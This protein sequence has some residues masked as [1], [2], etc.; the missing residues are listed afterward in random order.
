[1]KKSLIGT[2]IFLGT[3]ITC[4]TIFA[5]MSAEVSLSASKQTV[6]PGEEVIV[7]LSVKDIQD[8]S[9]GINAIEGVLE[10]DSSVFSAVEQNDSSTDF[11]SSNSWDSPVYYDATGKFVTSKA[12]YVTADEEIMTVKLK[13]KET[14]EDGETTVKVKNVKVSNTDEIY[15]LSTGA[16]V[17]INIAKETLQNGENPT[18]NENNEE[19]IEDITTGSTE[20][21][22]DAINTNVDVSKSK[23]STNP[24]KTVEDT[25]TAKTVIPKTGVA[26]VL[27]PVMAMLSTVS[28]I[29][30]RK[31]KNTY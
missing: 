24:T 2:S 22:E 5:A 7:H 18:D 3:C 30:Y 1:M 6:K 25:T 26:K 27:V 29:S 10:Y 13:V 17:K 4:T 11:T 9:K 12:T 14:A 19:P 8:T 15:E 23:T 16:E 21:E 31:Y 20:D 28:V